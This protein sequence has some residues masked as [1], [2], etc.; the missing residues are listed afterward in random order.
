MQSGM[1]ETITQGCAAMEALP[2]YR[3]HSWSHDG[4][5]NGVTAHETLSPELRKPKLAF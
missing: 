5:F 1:P 2:F 3:A 4:D